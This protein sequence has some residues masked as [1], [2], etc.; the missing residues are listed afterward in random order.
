M[1]QHVCTKRSCRRHGTIPSRIQPTNEK[2]RLCI[3]FYPLLFLFYS[4]QLQVKSFS[5]IPI[6][7]VIF[8]K[9]CAYYEKDYKHIV[10]RIMLFKHLNMLP[11]DGQGDDGCEPESVRIGRRLH[12]QCQSHGAV[13]AKVHHVPQ[14]LRKSGCG[15]LYGSQWLVQQRQPKGHRQFG[16]LLQWSIGVFYEPASKT[17]ILQYNYKIQ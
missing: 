1:R 8:P 11:A 10:Y 9:F 5:G 14:S 12:R 13:H 15:R 2:W 17:P 6:G 4:S 16:Q 7:D 3:E